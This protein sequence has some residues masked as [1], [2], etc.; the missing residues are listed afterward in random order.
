MDSSVDG[1]VDIISSMPHEILHHILSFIPTQ[2]AIRT[3]A[4]SR[5]WRHIWCHTPFLDFDCS[6]IHGHRRQLTAR[7]INQTIR[8]YRS[9]KVTSFHLSMSR[10]IREH[11]INS[12]IE[13]VLSRNVEKLSLVFDGLPNDHVFEKIFFLSSSLT[14]LCIRN[15][16]MI[17]VV[18]WKSLRNLTLGECNL[19]DESIPNILS[20]SP[21]LETLE[22]DYCRGPQRLDLSKSRSLRRL[23][24]YLRKEPTEIVAPH[25]HYLSLESF[26]DGP[27]TLVDVSSLAEA[28]IHIVVD[29]YSPPLN[30]NFLQTMVLKLLAKLQNILSLVEL[31]GVPFPTFKVETLTVETRFTRS[32]IPGLA[33][34]KKLVRL[35]MVRRSLRMR[36][37]IRIMKHLVTWPTSKVVLYVGSL[38]H[39]FKQEGMRG[40]YRGLSPTVMALLSKLGVFTLFLLPLFLNK[41]WELI[42]SHA[43]DEVHKLSGVGANVMAASGAATTIATNHPL[44]VVKTRLQILSLAELHGVPFP[45]FK[46][47]TLTVET[48]FTRYVIP[49]LAR[50]LQNSPE[51]KKLIAHAGYQVGIQDRDLDRYMDSEGLNRDECWRS[52]YEIL[53]LAELHGVP[54]PTFKV[55]TLTVETKFTRYVIP[56]L[57]R[58]LQNSPELKKLIAHAGYQVGIQDRDLDRYMDSEAHGFVHG[59]GDEKR[60]NTR[61]VGGRVEIYCY[62]VSDARW[63]EDLLQMLPTLSNNNNVSIVLKR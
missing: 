10:N 1:T 37:D 32:V 19:N 26:N 6:Y 47:E 5:G 2:F 44:W 13:F 41:Q 52:K 27:C 38:E 49:G 12:W 62:F 39:I 36:A 60:K 14:Q 16:D 17:A 54:F 9:P 11:E 29:N 30:L 24:I 21:V 57:A 51:L 33:R 3:S 45:T 42:F 35:E 63:F 15:F 59:N 53:S 8:S 20:G 25:L 56:G 23:V 55:E 50:L 22:L 28:R 40:L 46:V 34:K 31:R 48:K 4:L 43:L 18:S 7:D 58:L 61:D